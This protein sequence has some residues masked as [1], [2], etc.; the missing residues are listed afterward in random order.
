MR[1]VLVLVPA[2]TV[3]IIA[4]VLLLTVSQT[5]AVQAPKISL[6]MVIAGNTY[7]DPGAGGNNS[8]TVGTIDNCLT[9]IPANGTQHNHGTHLIIQ[10][11]EDVLGYQVRLNFDG[12]RMRPLTW[13][14]TPFTDTNTGQNVGFVNLPAPSGSHAA[15]V[16]ISDFSQTNTALVGGAHLGPQ[17]FANSPD[18]PAKVTPDDTSYSAP[19][20]G[21][22]GTLI[23]QVV[24]DQTGQAS[25]FVDVD[26]DLPNAPGSGVTI[27]NGSGQSSINLTE[28]ALF[29][30][31]HG[32]GAACSAQVPP[33][34]TPTDT[35]IP[36]ATPTPGPPTATPT[37]TPVATATPTGGAATATPTRTPTPA[38]GAGT[39]AATPT[40]TATPRASPAALPPTGS[41]T[42]DGGAAGWVYVLLLAA[43]AVPVS[44]TAYLVI[45]AQRR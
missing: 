6:D 36:T 29:D 25:L 8:M 40:R 45:R 34:P 24:G 12:S 13:N 30:G 32:E 27:W 43:L 17:D 15:V 11:V 2:L 14:P 20:G 18:T 10:D 21:I 44:A 1:R 33:T 35:P 16:A 23:L 4:S 3:A 7:S 39:A 26:D 37:A 31:F 41:T 5:R 22:L 9:S 42:S 38:A 28:G 19:T